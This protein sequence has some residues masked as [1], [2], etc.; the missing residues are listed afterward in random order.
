MSTGSGATPAGA[1]PFQADAT[2]SR[3]GGAL[4]PDGTGSFAGPTNGKR[5][6][7]CAICCA[8]AAERGVP[9]DGMDICG[10]GGVSGAPRPTLLKPGS[11][12]CWACV[13]LV[14]Q[15]VAKA[16]ANVIHVMPGIRQRRAKF[17]TGS[18][19]VMERSRVT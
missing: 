19:N 5:A 15:S 1:P 18:L 3:V 12:T 8:W 2:S 4:P 9:K 16:I 10:N 7:S 13:A 14:R 6:I 11:A 17:A